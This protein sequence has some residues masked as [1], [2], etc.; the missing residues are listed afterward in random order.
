MI[1]SAK[2]DSGDIQEGTALLFQQA[3][4][5]HLFERLVFMS[6]SRG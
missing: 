4:D 3:R 6:R 1:L 5:I 2:S